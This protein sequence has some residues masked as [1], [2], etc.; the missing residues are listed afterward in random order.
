[1]EGSTGLAE[2]RLDVLGERLR[3]VGRRVPAQDAVARS[4]RNLVKFHLIA[5]V[6]RR[7]PRFLF[8]RLKQRVGV[9]AIDLDLGEH[10]ER[11]IILVGAELSDF[12][13]VA[14]FLMAELIAREAEHRE[15]AFAKAPMQRFEARILG[16]EA[17]L[18]CDVDDEQRLSSEI[19]ERA[20]LAVDC[21]KRN[22]GGRGM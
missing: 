1:M 18:A 15:A 4:V 11:H 12:G 16:S 10:R 13:L 9:H 7:P 5:C 14:R 21:L 6:P 3:F 20:R 17:A 8:E 22:V 19:P 2:R